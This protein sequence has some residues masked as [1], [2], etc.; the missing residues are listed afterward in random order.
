MIDRDWTR[1]AEDSNGNKLFDAEGKPQME[2]VPMLRQFPLFNAEQCDDLPGQVR[3]TATVTRPQEDFAGVS[4]AQLQQV[5]S[6]V[7]APGMQFAPR[8]QNR[9]YYRAATDQIVLPLTSQSKVSRFTANPALSFRLRQL[10]LWS[11]EG[12]SLR[13]HSIPYDF[14]L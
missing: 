5:L 13:P 7:N 3:G 6:V 1:Q 12:V 2:T 4:P 8:S 9:A 14:G 11:P 10:F